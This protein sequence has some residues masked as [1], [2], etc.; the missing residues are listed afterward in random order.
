MHSPSR[1]IVVA[2]LLLATTRIASGE[3]STGSPT[4]PPSQLRHALY[5]EFLGKGGLWGLGYSYQLRPRLALGV[6]ASLSAFDRQRMWSASPSVTVYPLGTRR[7]RA[8][9][10]LG[11][12]LVHVSTPS[13]VPEWMGTSSTGIG[14]QLSTGYEHHGRVLVRAFVMGVVGKGGIAPWAGADMGCAF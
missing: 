9:L 5:L 11:P 1:W 8:F 3:P 7:H 10:D 14:A 12:Q 2:A 13:P 6:V 4:T